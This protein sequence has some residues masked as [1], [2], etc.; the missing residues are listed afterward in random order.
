LEEVVMRNSGLRENG[1]GSSGSGSCAVEIRDRVR[2]L[3]RV[4]ASDLRLNPKNWRRHPKVQADALRGLLAEIGYADALLARELPDGSLML[5]D[6]HLRAGITPDMEVAVLVLDLTEDEADKLLLT[7]DPLAGMAQADSERIKELLAT[8]RTDD[9]AVG[10][11]LEMIANQAEPRANQQGP[12]VDP[13]PQIDQAAELQKKWRTEQDQRWR[14]GPHRL[15]CGDSTDAA[16]VARLFQNRKARMVWTDPPYGVSYASK[17]EYMNRGD[18]GNRIQRPIE[19]DDLSPIQ[20]REL[21]RRALNQALEHAVPGAVCYASVPSGPLLPMFIAG[22]NDAGFSFKHQLIWLKQQFVIGMSDYH[23]R[24]ES[25]L[26]GW[27]ENG[28]PSI[29]LDFERAMRDSVNHRIDIGIES[30]LDQAQ[31]WFF[32]SP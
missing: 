2:E 9:E 20:V 13:E 10:A 5:I 30:E 31:R 12:L 6:G 11:L 26:Y 25:I 14:I 16:L 22:Y 21:F 8:V 29:A 7:L 4:K 1:A 17:N 15:A 24:Y 19:N 18:R 32:R 28:D 23:Y 3:R 27:R